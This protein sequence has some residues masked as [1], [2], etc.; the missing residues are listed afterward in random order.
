MLQLRIFIWKYHFGANVKIL[1]KRYAQVWDMYNVHRNIRFFF[2]VAKLLI[3]CDVSDK[4]YQ[5]F[6]SA[7]WKPSGL[8][9]FL[10]IWLWI[11]NN[12]FLKS[13][14]YFLNI[15]L[16]ANRFEGE[17]LEDCFLYFPT[18]FSLNFRAT[19]WCAEMMILKNCGLINQ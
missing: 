11:K 8:I 10:E 1:H 13:K 4:I 14:V 9:N 2:H 15:H 12:H 6:A 19:C 7:N 18:A 3:Y 5:S 16:M 17:T